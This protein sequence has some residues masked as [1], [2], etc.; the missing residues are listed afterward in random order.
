MVNC[1][2]RKVCECTAQHLGGHISRPDERTLKQS[3]TTSLHLN[4]V[5]TRS[6]NTCVLF[7]KEP[8]THRMIKN[9]Q[10]HRFYNKDREMFQRRY[11]YR[12][13]LNY[14]RPCSNSTLYVIFLQKGLRNMSDLPCVSAQ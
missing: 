2:T 7:Q 4:T 14:K 3:F 5:V 12:N 6:V 1:S 8:F 13:P 9:M 11:L 10:W